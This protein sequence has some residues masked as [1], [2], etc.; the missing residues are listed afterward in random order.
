MVARLRSGEDSNLKYC[1]YQ[2]QPSIGS[3]AEGSQSIVCEISSGVRVGD[4]VD[5]G[6]S[7]ALPISEAPGNLGSFPRDFFRL[8]FLDWS[9]RF[10]TGGSALV[11][12]RIER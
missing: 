2:N 8:F 10:L 3:R 11:P 7:G 5:E 9:D 4:G 12:R 6:S 1:W